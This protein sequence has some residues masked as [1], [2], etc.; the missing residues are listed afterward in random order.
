MAI[1]KKSKIINAGQSVDIRE[2]SYTFDG[3]VNWYSHSGEHYVG[4]L[5][6]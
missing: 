4:S 1:I 5:K 3:N 2:P 6:N